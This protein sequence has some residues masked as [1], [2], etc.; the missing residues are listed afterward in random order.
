MNNP[1]SCIPCSCQV[2]QKSNPDPFIG[3]AAELIRGAMRNMENMT[4]ELIDFSRGNTHL[5]LE[6]ILVADFL[7][8]IETEF[9]RYRPENE[10]RF[11]I[12][13][14]GAIQGDRHRLLRVFHNLIRNACE[15][16]TK[17]ER[18]ILTFALKRTDHGLRFEISDTGCGIPL[19]LQPRIF[20]PF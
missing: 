20:E 4:R 1:I 13:Y 11:E 9:A 10:L 7:E 12:F 6:L 3:E 5:N 16:M 15:A 17:S 18:K 19:E 8:E 14:N 2:I